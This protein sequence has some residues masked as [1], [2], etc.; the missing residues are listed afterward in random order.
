VTSLVVLHLICLESISSESLPDK[1]RLF[2]GDFCT[3]FKDGI[4]NEELPNLSLSVLKLKKVETNDSDIKISLGHNIEESSTD[5]TNYGIYFEK[6][7]LRN[8]PKPTETLRN[9]Y[10]AKSQLEMPDL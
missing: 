6:P 9:I 5:N 7:Q 2:V 4:S 1:L 8:V 3:C 10:Q